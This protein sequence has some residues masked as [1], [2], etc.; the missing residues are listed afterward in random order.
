MTE[1]ILNELVRL[2]KQHDIKILYAVESGSRAWGFASA[3]SDWDVRYIYI[4]KLEWYLQI[5]A[6]R[7]N[8]EEILPN[9][10]DL[11]GW[12]LRKALR[13]FRKSN[14]PMLEWLR[15]PIVYLQKYSTAAQLR[16]LTAYYFNPK[17]CIY[18]YLH[19]AEGNFQSYLQK[20]NVRVKKY[21]YVLRP[22]LACDWIKNTNTMAPTEF[23]EL[24]ES[25]V[26]D[27]LV[28][29][30]ILNLLDRKSRGD[31]LSEEPKIQVLHDFLEAKILF[32]KEY[33]KT[34]SQTI[35]PDTTLLN[36]LFINTL[37]EAWSLD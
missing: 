25:Q 13:L 22:I 16:H 31:E 9:D 29:E 23:H 18:H 30:E 37:E 1:E 11:A 26:D 36:A 17:S 24:L 10:I 28:K 32:Y 6:Q 7:D 14:P 4:H 8:Q 35:Q 15:S 2:E 20:E 19:M 5:D 34:V 27:H 12:E 21:F 3:D 33:V